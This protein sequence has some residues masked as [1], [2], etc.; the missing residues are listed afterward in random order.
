MS[1]KSY[2]N[3]L[4]W[5][6]KDRPTS[7]LTGKQAGWN[8]NLSTYSEAKQFCEDNPSFRLGICFSKDLPF[9]GL[10]LDSCID[11]EGKTESWAADMLAKLSTEDSATVVNTS[12]SGTGVKVILPCS[13]SIKRGV[14]FVEAKR[15]G[16]HVPQIEL[17]TDNKY[18][19]LTESLVIVEDAKEVDIKSLSEVMGYDVSQIEEVKPSGAQAGTTSPDELKSMLDKLDIMDY[20]NRQDWIR[21]MQA[22]HHGTAGSQE[23]KEVFNDWSSGDAEQYNKHSVDRDWDSLKL[24]AA[25]PVTVA[26][27]VKAM[28]PEDRPRIEPESDF[29]KLPVKEGNLLPWLLN[30]A[31]RNH[32]NVVRQLSEDPEG[33]LCKF[34]EDWGQW[35]I[36]SDGAWRIDSGGSRF[37]GIVMEFLCRLSSRIP[38]SGGEESA[39]AEAWISNLLNYNNTNGVIKQAKGERGLRI[40]LGDIG[41]SPYLLNFRN[42]TYDLKEDK[43]RGHSP[44]DFCFHQ[45]NTDYVEGQT[46]PTWERVINDVFAGDDDLI[47]YVRRLLGLSITGNCSDPVFNIFYGDGCN[48]KSTIVQCIAD[49]LGS[50]SSHLP[51][52]LLDNR[53]DMHPTYM[54]KL[55]NARLAIFAEMEADVPL[56]E[57]TVKKLTS[58]DTIE[59]RRMRENPWHF[60]PS[61]TSVICTNHRP[62]IKGRDAGIWRR[63][64]LVP[65]TVNLEDKKDITIPSKLRE[66]LAGVANWLIQGYREF[67]AMGV[68]TCKAVDEATEMYRVNEDEFARVAE[69]LFTKK[70]GSFVLVVDAF[71]SYVRTGGRLG[72]KKFCME[73]ER[74]GLPRTRKSVNGTKPYVFQN[75]ALSNNEF[76]V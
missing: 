42:G 19:A 7:A 64:R 71:Q 14:R 4:V 69:D 34:V 51:S 60:Q 29:D 59:A 33:R 23:G 1:I 56:A 57:S 39:K 54:A 12:V 49:L 61:H 13:G 75:I 72:R 6:R 62:L 47:R 8:R 76:G 65:F 55:H 36:Y 31:S 11:S 45:C 74:I 16:G 43:F 40:G 22:A 37:H 24:D 2:K 73:M 50:Y 26:T 10:D 27:I 38:E 41:E 25:R 28:K 58:Q 18:F 44:E 46:S 52:E 66:E 30:E 35:I 70:A 68:G 9:V 5:E 20:Q 48:G 3:W 53:K 63:L 17:F 15:H 21:M 32:S 67:V